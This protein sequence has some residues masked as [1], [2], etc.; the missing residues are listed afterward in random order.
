MTQTRQSSATRIA[1]LD[2]LRGIAVVLMVVH[3]FL[4]DLV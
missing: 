4:Y 3:H 1:A 2:V